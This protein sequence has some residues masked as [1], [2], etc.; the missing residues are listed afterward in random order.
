MNEKM[1]LNFADDSDNALISKDFWKHVKS[2]TKSTIIPETV[3]YGN[4]FRGNPTEQAHLFNEYFSHQF[5]CESKYDIAIDCSGN[6]FFDLKFECDDVY[7]IL[8]GLNPSKAPGPDGIHGK[9][10]KYCAKS[11]AYPLSILFNLSFVT[12]CIPPDWKL[13]SVVPVFKKGDKNSLV[14][15]VFERC[16]RTSLFTACS[17]LLDPRQHGFLADKSCITQMIPFP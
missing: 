8:R 17:D 12:G 13:A 15:K 1:R 16:V 7:Q 9:V 2:R 14:M 4:R 10:L 5:S 3:V 6:N 11:L